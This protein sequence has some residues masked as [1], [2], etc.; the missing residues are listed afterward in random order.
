[1]STPPWSGPS[2][3]TDPEKE[4]AY[5]ILR[6][7][8]EKNFPPESSSLQD[9]PNFESILFVGRPWNATQQYAQRPKAFDFYF[10]TE[11]SGSG[12]AGY[13][14]RDVNLYRGRVN[15]ETGEVLAENP[16]SVMKR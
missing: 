7:W 3:M 8:F 1:M 16:I 5:D 13:Y 11:E 14:L 4:R 6:Q 9:F 12:I 10:L 2:Y 15:L